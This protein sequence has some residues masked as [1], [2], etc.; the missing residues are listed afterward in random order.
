MICVGVVGA[1]A[2]TLSF[3]VGGPDAAFAR[4]EALLL[5]MGRRAVHC[6]ASGN[7]LAAK[8]ANKCARACPRARD[9]IIEA[10]YSL[11]LGISMLGTAE[12]MLLGTKLGLKPDLLADILNT[13]TGKCWASEVNNPYPGALRQAASRP[14][15]DRGYTGGCV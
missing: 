13:S 6:G 10:V 3:M 11:L 12:A 5:L 9:L 2:G 14:P 15:A 1:N 8:I 7:G 4:A